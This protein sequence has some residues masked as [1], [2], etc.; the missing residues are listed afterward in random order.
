MKSGA[1][2]TGTPRIQSKWPA[3]STRFVCD[4]SMTP[5]C[6]S[7]V[8]RLWAPASTDRAFRDCTDPSVGTYCSRPLSVAEGRTGRRPH[9]RPEATLPTAKPADLTQYRNSSPLHPHTGNDDDPLPLRPELR[10]APTMFV[11]EHRRVPHSPVEWHIAVVVLRYFVAV[12]IVGECAR[13]TG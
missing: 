11:A 6:S 3:S 5:W 1:R 13:A 2:F 4:G 8:W 9:A 7:A 10:A 12:L